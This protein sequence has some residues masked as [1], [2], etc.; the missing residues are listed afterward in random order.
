MFKEK[1][2][3]IDMR[4]CL[5]GHFYFIIALGI[6]DIAQCLEHLIFCQPFHDLR[7]IFIQSTTLYIAVYGVQTLL[8]YLLHWMIIRK[9]PLFS[10]FQIADLPTGAVQLIS[11]RITAAV[12]GV[13][14]VGCQ[15][16]FAA[17]PAL[18]DRKSTRLNSSHSGEYRMPSSA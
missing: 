15:K 14:C 2:S 12:F 3:Q 17:D 7:K 10:A 8:M 5:S 6:S 1:Q 13:P 16:P 11:R 9:L 18:L 4:I